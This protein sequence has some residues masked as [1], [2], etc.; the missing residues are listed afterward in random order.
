MGVLSACA[1]VS[2]CVP[3][4]GAFEMRGVTARTA[5]RLA[6][7]ESGRHTIADSR[8]EPPFLFPAHGR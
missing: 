8:F 3:R 4:L 1:P 7:G 2:L 6:S 5:E